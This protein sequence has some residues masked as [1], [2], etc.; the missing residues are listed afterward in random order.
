MQPERIVQNIHARRLVASYPDYPSAQAAV[1][2]LAAEQYPVEHITISGEGI[3][4]VERVSGPY[5]SLQAAVNGILTGAVG[6][7]LFGLVFGALSL[8]FP[9]APA[10][11]LAFY[12]AAYGAFIGLVVALL[13]HAVYGR[14]RRFSSQASVRADRYELLVDEVYAEEALRLL[15]RRGDRAAVAA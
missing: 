12:G 10:L 3:R 5:G 2:Y 13:M 1:D 14:T 4:L 6:G 11:D 8:I 9:V 15:R 7:A